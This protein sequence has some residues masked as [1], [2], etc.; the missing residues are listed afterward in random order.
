MSGFGS[1]RLGWLLGIA[2]GG[3]SA[4]WVNC[5]LAQITPDGTLPNNSIVTPDG[6]ILNITEG[7]Q[8]G[9]NLFHIGQDVNAAD[10][11]L[12]TFSN[13]SKSEGG[14]NVTLQANGFISLR[15]AYL[16]TAR[17]NGGNISLMGSDSMSITENSF[18]NAG[19][20]QGNS[21]S[22]VVTLGQTLLSIAQTDKIVGITK[23]GVF[24]ECSK[25]WKLRNMF[26]G[27]MRICGLAIWKNIRITGLRQKPKMN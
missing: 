25:L 6:S 4:C 21:G 23:I 26:T 2:I 22:P 11:L 16:N 1:T 5:A 8:A 7:T 20:S 27:K 14:G 18:L 15:S 17:P 19:T 24:C 10:E 3:I 12:S 13:E 9:G